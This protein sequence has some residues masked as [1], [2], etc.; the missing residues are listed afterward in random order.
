MDAFLK[1]KGIDG[2]SQDSKHKSWIEILSYSFNASQP[3]GGGR[4][5]TGAPGG[6]RVNMS[7]LVVTKQLDKTSPKIFLQVCN[8]KP[9]DE[10]TLELCR[11]TGDKQKYLEV[12]MTDVLISNW[13]HGH[14]GKGDDSVPSE[15]FSLNCGEIEWIYTATDQKTGKAAGDVKAKWSQVENKGE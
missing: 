11:A 6:A 7:D 8:G 10:I 13:S 15:T 1:I 4:S 5:G 9:I 14:A 2:E 12:K 3:S